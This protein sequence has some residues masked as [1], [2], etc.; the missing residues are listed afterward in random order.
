[1]T[2]PRN[3]SENR[4]YRRKS[5]L[6]ATIITIASFGV[7]GATIAK[8]CAKAGASRGMSAHYFKNKEELLTASFAHI[9][10]DASA[11]K[12]TIVDSSELSAIERIYRCAAESFQPPNFGWENLAAWQAFTSAS[13]YTPGFQEVIKTY[14]DSLFSTYFSLF[15]EAN[16]GYC[17]SVSE[18]QATLGL[19]ALL[20]GLW[21]NIAMKKND[22]TAKSAI[23]ACHCYIDGCFH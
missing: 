9:F 6:R 1:V 10:E 12:Q 19:L 23:K 7:E 14:N 20:D 5:L 15:S 21:T 17:M 8:I 22:I 16:T 13:T 18:E 3:Q 2:K 4:N 11:T